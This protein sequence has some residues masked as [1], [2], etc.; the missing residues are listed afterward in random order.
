MAHKCGFTLKVLL[1]TLQSNGFAAVAG[2]RRINAFD[3]WAVASKS[4]LGDEEVRQLAATY[5]PS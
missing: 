3:L 2:K 1:A 4:A 5:L